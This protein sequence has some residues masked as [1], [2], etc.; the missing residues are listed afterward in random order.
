MSIAAHLIH[1]CTISRRTASGS[2][3][4]GNTTYTYTDATNVPCR[5]VEKRER[6]WTETEGA[7]IERSILLM[8]PPSQEVAEGDIVS[9]VTLEDG[10]TLEKRYRVRSVLQRRGRAASHRSV[11]L[12]AAA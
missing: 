11:S 2:D 4:H 7:R 8:L 3:A 9:A 12:E 5:Y 10:S 1:T 6:V